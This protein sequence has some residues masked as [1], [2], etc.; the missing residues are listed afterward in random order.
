MNPDHDISDTV[1]EGPVPD[2]QHRAE[3]GICEA[4][5]GAQSPSNAPISSARAA[6]LDIGV[7]Q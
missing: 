7:T 4:P 2:Q 3:R 5:V 6:T 1:V